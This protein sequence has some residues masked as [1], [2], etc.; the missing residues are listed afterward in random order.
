MTTAMKRIFGNAGGGKS[1]IAERLAEMTGLSLNPLDLI[2][3]RPDGAEMPREQYLQVHAELRR[4]D[5][6][7]IDGFGCVASAWERF[8]RV[9]SLVYVGL[10]LATHHWWVTKRLAKGLF[11]NPEGWPSNSPIWASTI[12]VHH[13]KSPR[14]IGAFSRR[15]QA[16]VGL[17]WRLKHLYGI[18]IGDRRP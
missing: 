13:L 18:Y 16:R 9:D 11:V 1:T 14:E 2:Q 3:H 12:I 10:P 4:R 15:S 5:E 6:W 8:A 7:I 17:R